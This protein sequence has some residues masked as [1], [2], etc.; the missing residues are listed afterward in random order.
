MS[1][2]IEERRE[3][4]KIIDIKVKSVMETY[5]MRIRETK[6]GRDREKGAKMH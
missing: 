6:I 1:S 5:Q 2:N 4:E 3:S